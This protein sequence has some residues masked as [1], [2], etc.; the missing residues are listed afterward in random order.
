MVTETGESSEKPKVS[1]EGN[2]LLEVRKSF[3]VSFC[4]SFGDEIE[5]QLH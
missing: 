2:L 1:S 4:L 5:N 3:L